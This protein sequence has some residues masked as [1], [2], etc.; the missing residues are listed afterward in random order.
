[1][2]GISTYCLIDQP[3]LVALDRLT[4]LTG[5]VEVMDEGPHLVE[6]PEL[7]ESHTADFILHAPY[8]GMNIACLFES[9]R[10]ASVEVMTDC[11]A[12]AAEIGAPVV[13]HPGYF[14]WEQ[15][16]EQANRQFAKSLTELEAAAREHSISFSFENMG[17]MNFFNLRTPADLALIDGCSFTLDVGHANLNG[18]LPAFLGT[19]FTHL[20]LHDNDGRRD[21][22]SPVGE[23][24]IDFPAVMAAMRREHAT[25]VVE[26]R[27]F[28]GAVA[29][30][31]AL[32]GM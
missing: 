27:Q 14:A 28:D 30:L 3:L 25:A 2:I 7:F 21:T 4:A 16:R 23:G 24:T 1:M 11:F 9:I 19:R 13:L 29:S 22:H 31:R 26:V 20:H 8:H 5:L 17:D 12:R 6:R 15:E 32:E 18:C 10:K